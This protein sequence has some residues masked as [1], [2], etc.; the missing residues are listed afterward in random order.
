MP[1]LILDPFAEQQFNELRASN[2]LSKRDEV[3]DGVTVVMPLPNVEHQRIVDFFQRV[4]HELFDLDSPYVCLPG[5]NVSDRIAGWKENYREPDVLLVREGG[6]ARFYEN[7]LYGG[8]EFL[9]EVV[10][11]GDKAREKL[12][13]YA[14]IGTKE[15][16]II[17]RDPWRLELYQL[18]RGKLRLIGAIV[19]GDGKSLESGVM[20]LK[21]SLVRGKPRPKIR[22][23]HAETEQ[24]WTT[25]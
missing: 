24:M 17:D 20:P 1:T 18:R 5:A 16:L 6:D 12:P 21:F 22:I 9:A 23:A 3:W 14:S 7:H 8:P 4:F 19:P 15:V 10:S 11:P 13:F 25:K 2:G